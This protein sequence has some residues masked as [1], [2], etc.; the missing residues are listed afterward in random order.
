MVKGSNPALLYLS[1]QLYLPKRLHIAIVVLL[2]GWG[3]SINDTKTAAM[4]YTLPAELAGNHF[5]SDHLGGK[6]ENRKLPI[7]AQ[8]RSHGLRPLH[9]YEASTRKCEP[10]KLCLHIILVSFL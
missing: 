6:Y 2:N 7:F 10:E 5:L 9:I 4:I 1:Y 8:F 3:I